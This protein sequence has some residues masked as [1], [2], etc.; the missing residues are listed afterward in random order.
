LPIQFGER[1]FQHVAVTRI[2][3]CLQ[4]LQ[5]MLAGKKQTFAFL[6]ALAVF[7]SAL[8]IAGRDYSVESF[9]LLE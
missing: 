4:L 1:L 3:G 2:A 7:F 6:D 9:S 5:E 8:G